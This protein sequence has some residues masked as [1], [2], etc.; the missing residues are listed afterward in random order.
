MEKKE[1][2]KGVHYYL[3]EGFVIFTEAYLIEKGECCGN[4]CR[5]CPYEKPAIKGD[6]IVVVVVE[7]SND[8]NG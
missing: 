3:E 1:F 7:G 6:T 8:N 2:V 4:S 5:H